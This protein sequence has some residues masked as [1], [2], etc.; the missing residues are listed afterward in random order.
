MTLWDIYAR[1]YDALPIALPSYP[2]T[3]ARV[4]GRL[5]REVPRAGRVLDAGCGTGNYALDLAARGY[6]V[7]G[8]DGSAAM[9]ARANKKASAQSLGVALQQVDLA[10]GLPFGDASFDAAVSVMVLYAMEN[11]A[12]LLRELRR[13]TRTHG[14]LIL[15]T[16]DDRSLVLPGVREVLHEHGLV[17]GSWRL[18]LLLGV[19]VLNA[20]I[21]ARFGRQ[22][23]GFTEAE[24]RLHLQDTGWKVEE[25]TPCYV[26]DAALLVVARAYDFMV[27]RARLTMASTPTNRGSEVV[28]DET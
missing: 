2:R 13:V 5:S 8:L 9:L 20:V 18:G 26:D 21:D 27:D 22:Y 11:P 4:C 24:L 25:A 1:A 3:V 15:V 17:R 7:V 16:T 19:G 28:W 6:D 10:A 14:V 23:V 12:A